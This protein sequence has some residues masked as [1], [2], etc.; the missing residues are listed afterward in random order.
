MMAVGAMKATEAWRILRSAPPKV[1]PAFI[2]TLEAGFATRWGEPRFALG[3]GGEARLLVPLPSGELPEGL[4]ESDALR[5]QTLLH[6]VGDTGI[7]LSISCVRI[8]PSR[9][10]LGMSLTRSLHA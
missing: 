9:L 7:A 5:I 8:P 6:D 4:A 2:P 3:A 10:S 1:D